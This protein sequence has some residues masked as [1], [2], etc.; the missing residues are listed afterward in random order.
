L[1]TGDPERTEPGGGYVAYGTDVG[2][3]SLQACDGRCGVQEQNSSQ[4][5]FRVKEKPFSYSIKKVRKPSLFVVVVE[6]LY[7]FSCE[8][9]H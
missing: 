7:L 8:S 3:Q 5:Q 1:S 2:T 6:T 4:N 9:L